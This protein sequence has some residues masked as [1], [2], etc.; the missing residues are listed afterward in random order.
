LGTSVLR[1]LGEEPA[2]ESV[3]GLARRI[4]HLGFPKTQ[5]VAANVGED[6]LEPIFAG[7]DAVVHLAWRL[8]PAHHPEELEQTNLHGSRRVIEAS[9]RAGVGALLVASSVGAYS[10]GPKDRLVDEAWPTDGIET[11]RYSRE[12]AAVER[13]LDQLEARS[14]S[15]RV[16][17]FRPALVFKRH[18]ASEI[19]RLFVGPL[20]PPFMFSPRRV[21]LVP[22]HPRFVFQCVHSLDV[23]VAFARAVVRDVSGAFNLATAPPLDGEHIAE[24]LHARPVAVTQSMMRKVVDWTWRLHLQPTDPGWID[25]AFGS[26]LMDA[27]RAARELDWHPEH[28]ATTTLLDLLDGLRHRDGMATPPLV[29]RGR[30]AAS[31]T[32]AS[33]ADAGHPRSPLPLQ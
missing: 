25:L 9:E 24:L 23:G 18:A 28:D 17:R 4:P 13:M 7:A 22:T 2:V 10:T 1:A 20:V 3:V 5:F 31:A 26:P 6:D 29:P 30:R 15:L 19:E 11:S 27:T 12:K 33:A 8:Q 32:D 16:V 14:P 21:P